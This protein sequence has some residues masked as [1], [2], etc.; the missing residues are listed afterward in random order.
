MAT[1][2]AAVGATRKPRGTATAKSTV[3]SRSA[4]SVRNPSR[5]PRS[6]LKVALKSRFKTKIRIV[7]DGRQRN[8]RLLYVAARAMRERPLRNRLRLVLTATVKGGKPERHYRLS[9]FPPSQGPDIELN[10]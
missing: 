7:Q 2:Q 3:S 6:E 10:A 5:S 8:R 4:G 1:Y 9:E